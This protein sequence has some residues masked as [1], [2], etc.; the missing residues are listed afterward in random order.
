MPEQGNE[1]IITE[2]DEGE[3]LVIKRTLKSQ[4]GSKDE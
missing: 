3:L 4:K 1:E 2:P